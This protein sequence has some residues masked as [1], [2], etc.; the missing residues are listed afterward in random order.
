MWNLLAP[1][2]QLTVLVMLAA[3]LVHAI[4]GVFAW[5]GGE[6]VGLFRKASM[7]VTVI[8]I[9]LLPLAE[10][11]WRPVWRRFP[12]LAR[13]L[14][15]DCSGVWEGE[16]HSTWKDPSTGL[17]IPP[18]TARFFI[19]QGLLS[20]SVRMSTGESSSHSTR[21][22]LEADPASRQFVI[23]YT[24]RNTP[25]AKVSERS[26]Q[27][28]GVAWLSFDHTASPPRMTG[29]YCTTR[30]TSGDIDIKRVSEDPD[31]PVVHLTLKDAG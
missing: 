19:F 8:G 18:I 12:I 29:R 9:I 21:C 15:P 20:T 23:A 28:D 3:V 5:I 17:R 4:D 11:V 14:F 31:G 30:H 27:H 6:Y 16:L 2:L 7:A 10:L 13:K 25:G 26:T 24:Y 1:K 22:W